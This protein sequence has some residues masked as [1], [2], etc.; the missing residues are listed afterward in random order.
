M[1]WFSLSCLNNIPN[2]RFSKS[3]IHKYRSPGKIEAVM[4][5]DNHSTCASK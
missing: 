1:V 2:A 5:A 4:K 3:V